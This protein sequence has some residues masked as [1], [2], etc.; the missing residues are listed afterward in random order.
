MLLGAFFKGESTRIRLTPS[1]KAQICELSGT[2][3]FSKALPNLERAVAATRMLNQDIKR[4]CTFHEVTADGEQHI[5]NF[6]LEP[7]EVEEAATCRD[8]MSHELIKEIV[9][10]SKEMGLETKTGKQATFNDAIP[11]LM[12][13]INMTIMLGESIK[14]GSKLLMVNPEGEQYA[15]KFI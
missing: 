2:D 1:L 7:C 6:I 11:Y 12:S 9:S 5:V 4:G 14:E 3:K 10:L 15:V 13:A 8:R